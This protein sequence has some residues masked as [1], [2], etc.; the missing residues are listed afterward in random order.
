MILLT[1]MIL[2]TTQMILS[3]ADTHRAGGDAFYECLG[4]FCCFHWHPEL[5]VHVHVV[6][7][8]LSLRNRLGGQPAHQDTA[9]QLPVNAEVA[10]CRYEPCEKKQNILLSSNKGMYVMAQVIDG[11]LVRVK[12]SRSH[13]CVTRNVLTMCW[14]WINVSVSLSRCQGQLSSFYVHW[15]HWIV[16]IHYVLCHKD[17]WKLNLDLHIQ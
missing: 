5:P 7:L 11:L 12:L 15:P 13:L 4:T 17:M 3:A 2:M 9:G 6:G 16:G 8:D 10:G 14:L 1:Q